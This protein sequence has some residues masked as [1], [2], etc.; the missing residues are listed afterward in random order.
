VLSSSLFGFGKEL[1]GGIR[2]SRTLARNFSRST[3]STNTVVV[4]KA[5]QYRGNNQVAGNAGHVFTGGSLSLY[6]PGLNG[7]AASEVYSSWV[8][9]GTVGRYQ[10]LN[11]LNTIDPNHTYVVDLFI[12][13]GGKTHEYFLHGSTQF[14]QTAEA[15]FPMRRI[16]KEYPLLSG[17]EKWTDPEQE[18]D[19][20]NWYGM[21]RDISAGQSP[22]KWD[23]TFRGVGS[24][25]IGTRIFML[26]DGS[27][28]VYLGKSPHS[29]RAKVYDNI[30]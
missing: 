27:S 28:Q 15:G 3:L 6:E 17:H 8:Y 4:N 22:G 30:Y 21:F 29:Y 18:G 2:Y 11:I 20:Q 16:V 12:V 9:P 23:V 7:I 26:D 1:L 13:T 14:D 19:N 5:D 10:R 24:G 25:S